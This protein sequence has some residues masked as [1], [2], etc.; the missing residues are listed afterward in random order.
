[1]ISRSKAGLDIQELTRK[2]KTVLEGCW[3]GHQTGVGLILV[4]ER[5]GMEGSLSECSARVLRMFDK[6]DEPS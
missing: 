2:R 1:M 5:C 3:E 6:A 4:K